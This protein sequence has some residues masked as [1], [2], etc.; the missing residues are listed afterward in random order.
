[1]KK[2]MFTLALL[3]FATSSFA[4]QSITTTITIGGSSF[5][6]SKQV[7]IYADVNGARTAYTATSCH[8]SGTKQYATAGGATLVDVSK[9]L[10]KDYT[11][12]ATPC[13]PDTPTAGAM[14]SGFN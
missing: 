9:I 13:V 11:G 8:T 2:L 5:S 6:P 1:M 4:A 14:P 12:T 10:Q 7:T 3:A